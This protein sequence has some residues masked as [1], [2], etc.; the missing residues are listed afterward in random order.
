MSYTKIKQGG[1]TLIELMV[2]IAIIGVLAGIALPAYKNYIVRSKMSEAMAVLTEGKLA[3]GEF[4][5]TRGR[6]PASDDLA[7][8]DMPR[9][10]D[11]DIVESLTYSPS[12]ANVVVTLAPSGLGSDVNG[13]HIALSLVS[14]GNGRLFWRCVPGPSNPLSKKHL[15]ANC[16]G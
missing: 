6:L 3:V 11:T 14:S 16:Q 1:F 8:L 15:P 2:V 7:A 9:T 5:S 10:L 12:S 13:R 4:F